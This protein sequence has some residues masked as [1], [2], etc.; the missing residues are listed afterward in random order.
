MTQ[1]YSI[2]CLLN[3][4]VLLRDVLQDAGGSGTAECAETSIRIT[5]CA[6]PAAAISV[7]LTAEGHAQPSGASAGYAAERAHLA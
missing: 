1:P 7:R 6:S 4:K 5:T 2:F 3:G